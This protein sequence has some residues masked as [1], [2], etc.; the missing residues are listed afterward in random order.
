MTNRFVCVCVCVCVRPEDLKL[1]QE[2]KFK[3]ILSKRNQEPRNPG[4]HVPLPSPVP[5]QPWRLRWNEM[6]STKEMK[7]DKE[8]V[9]TW[10]CQ[11]YILLDN[12][13]N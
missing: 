3:T 11:P 8:E 12:L 4:I 2:R 6:E 10:F 9:S 1:R 13:H 5:R 7:N